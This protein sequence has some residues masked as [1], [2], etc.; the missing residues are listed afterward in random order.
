MA[1]ELMLV[2]EFNIAGILIN[3][4]YATTQFTSYL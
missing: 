3:L 2:G 1:Q 4:I